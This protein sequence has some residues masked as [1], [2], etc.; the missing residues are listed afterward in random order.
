MVVE[1]LGVS[2]GIRPSVVAQGRKKRGF[3][4]LQ[5]HAGSSPFQEACSTAIKNVLTTRQTEIVT[6]DA[7]S[8]REPRAVCAVPI[9]SA[10]SEIFG[11]QLWAGRTTSDPPERENVGTFEYDVLR[12]ETLH[13]PGLEERILGISDEQARS[14]TLPEIWKYFDRFDDEDDYWGYMD[15]I[16]QR[17]VESGQEFSGEIYLTGADGV[18]RQVHMTVRADIAETRIRM[19]GLVHDTSNGDIPQTVYDRDFVRAAVNLDPSDGSGVGQ[20]DLQTGVIFEWLRN[21][22]APF[23]EWVAQN[24]LVHEDSLPG[25]RRARADLASGLA[26]KTRAVVHI[27]FAESAHWL[28]TEVTITA[29]GTPETANGAAG[30]QGVVQVKPFEHDVGPLLW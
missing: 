20:M 7:D 26:S 24:P 8:F 23:L 22:C 21:P 1:T 19:V 10:Q 2:D 4:S 15:Q 14:R 11:V 30:R 6:V 27:K 12:N 16:K 3:A 29:V 17:L 25:F 9:F 28:P 13:G 18:R 5:R